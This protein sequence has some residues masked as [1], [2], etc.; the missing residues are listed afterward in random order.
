VP[1][2]A[3]LRVYDV[4]GHLLRELRAND[5]GTIV[6]GLDSNSGARIASG[7]VLYKLDAAD[8]SRRGRLV[9]MR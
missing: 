7:I 9:V 5:S 8:E 6:W 3:T 2:G 1:A 4:A